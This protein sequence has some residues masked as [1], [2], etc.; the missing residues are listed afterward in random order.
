MPEIAF[1]APLKSPGHPNP[2]GD[3]QIARLFVQAIETAGHNVTLASQFRPLERTGD[4]QR[5]QRLISIGQC[6]AERLLRHWQAI[7]YRPDLWFTYHLY[8]K[9]PDLLGPYICQQLGIPYVVAEASHSP[10]Q[11][12][13]PWQ[14]FHDRVDLALKQADRICCINPVDIPALDTFCSGHH[15]AG[16]KRIK[17][18]PAFIHSAAVTPVDKADIAR[19]YN[20]QPDQPWLVTIAMMRPGDK[21]ESYKLLA[22]A[23]H[24]S[25]S[26]F[27]LLVIGG[28]KCENEVHRLLQDSRVRFA[29]KL[30]NDEVMQLLPHFSLNLWP[31]VNEALGLNFLESQSAGVPVIAGDERGVHSVVQNGVTGILCPMRDSEALAKALDQ[32]LSDSD[33]LSMMQRQAPDYVEQNHSLQSTA[34][35]LDDIFQELIPV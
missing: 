15:G 11:A 12:F 18:L 6:L 9:S 7:G 5:Q 1:Y 30:D 16:H 28:G 14:P 27:N 4:N 23:L 17:T 20:L 32:L 26:R 3:R 29:G 19:K 31:A 10:K 34:E 21:L 25:H 33:R 22:E 13:G 35:R 24:K 8:Y 2:S